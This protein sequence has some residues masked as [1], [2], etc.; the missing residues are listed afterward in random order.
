MNR[1]NKKTFNCSINSLLNFSHS[2]VVSEMS[3]LFHNMSNRYFIYHIEQLCFF[4]IRPDNPTLFN[5]RDKCIHT[6]FDTL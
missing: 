2:S 6:V 3:F 4:E 5:M 1:S